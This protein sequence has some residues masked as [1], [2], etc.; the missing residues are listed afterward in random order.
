MKIAIVTV[1][2]P[3]IQGGAEFLADGL[4]TALTRHGHETDMVTTP[5]AFGPASHVRRSA[6]RW[7]EE[8]LNAYHGH[9]DLAVCLK[10]PAYHVGHPNK[11]LWLL[12]QHRGS[13]DLW[14][15][16]VT[17]PADEQ[18]LRS[19]IMASDTKTLSAI[20]RRFTIAQTVT[21]R[22]QRYNGLPS[23]ALYHPPPLA[24]A[25]Y[26]R[27]PEMYIW[28][29]SRLEDL[30]RQRL[31]IEAMSFVNNAVVALI[32][33]TG[34][35]YQAYADI[36]ARLGLHDRVKLLGAVD[37][38][39]MLAGYAMS[40]GVFFGPYDEDYGYVT[41]EAMLAA[42]PVITCTDSGGPNE[43]VID[44]ETGFCVPPHPK[45]VADA[46]NRLAANPA[47]ASAMGRAGNEAYAAKNIGWDDVVER[48]I[49]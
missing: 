28:C 41:L 32:A 4:R 13:Y 6:M 22:L 15:D 44:G 37:R 18:A 49:G 39:T 26:N 21:A 42:K 45:A 27:P 30:K 24:S 38:E 16:G 29:P 17:H 35:Q 14:D 1:K 3:F 47:R 33:G 43:F 9:V 31:L 40:L 36:I 48:L 19:E 46:I 12:H 23:Q 34:G 5:F 2:T 7:H 11:V 25:L 10:F 20:P 8:D